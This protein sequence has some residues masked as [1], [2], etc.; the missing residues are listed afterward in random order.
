MTTQARLGCG[1]KVYYSNDGSTYNVLAEAMELSFPK[2]TAEQIDVSNHDSPIVG[3]LA[4]REYI[5]G[6]VKPDSAKLTFNYTTATMAVLR[7]LFGVVKYWRL[8]LVDTHKWESQGT[9]SVLEQKVP[10]D[11]QMTIE[12]ELQ[13]TGSSVYT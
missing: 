13:L 12:C 1:A 6:M 5:S 9:L 4:Y 10:V 11:K 8:V 2:L 7:S 3:G